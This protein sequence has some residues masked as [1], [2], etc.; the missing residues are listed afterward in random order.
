MTEQEFRNA[1]RGVMTATPAP[2]S[3]NST[4]VLDAAQRAHRRRRAALAGTASAAAVVLI[5]AGAIAVTSLTRDDNSPN[6]GGV[7]G[8]AGGSGA[9]T[10]DAP[11]TKTSWPDGQTDRTASQGPR[12]DKGVELMDLLTASVPA[13][14]QS[15][16]DLKPAPGAELH[17]DLRTHQAQFA[18]E[19]AGKQI[20]EYMVSIPVGANGKW[21]RLL[22]EVHTAGNLVPGD[23]CALTAKFWGMG[24][25]CQLVT[26]G[27]KQVGVAIRPTGDDRFDQWAGYRHPDGTVVFIAQARMYQMAGLP[28]L[29][30]VPLTPQQLAEL[31]ADPKFHLS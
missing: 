9:V 17:G 30:G 22:A 14:L 19:V 8:P 23:G 24:G 5:A 11:D 31:A 18:D 20:W 4:V 12:A 15:P 13:G 7:G 28:E 21:G 26:V 1:L 2:P 27:D 29:A 3:M 16:T 10:T 6:L 25:E